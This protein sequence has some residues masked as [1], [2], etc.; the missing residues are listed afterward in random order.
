MLGE[1]YIRVK[2][3]NQAGDSQQQQQGNSTSEDM[4]GKSLGDAWA[5]ARRVEHRDAGDNQENGTFFAYE[6][7]EIVAYANA[8][9]AKVSEEFYPAAV[10][11]TDLSLQTKVAPAGGGSGSGGQKPQRMNVI[12]A[13]GVELQEPVAI[14]YFG[15]IISEKLAR[16]MAKSSMLP[17]R[18]IPDDAVQPDLF[19]EGGLANT[20][21]RTDFSVP[22]LIGP[23]M[24]PKEEAKEE[25]EQPPQPPTTESTPSG[26]GPTAS[27]PQASP[28]DR[29]RKA[30][31]KAPPVATH[32]LDYTKKTITITSRGR[33][34]KYGL[35]V[36]IDRPMDEKLV[37]VKCYRE[38]T[39]WD[40][41][42]DPWKVK[43]AKSIK[44]SLFALL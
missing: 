41:S 19:L 36:L 33:T 27:V 43:R 35:P 10:Q 30:A 22:W 7:R 38:P 42:D 34:F 40:L 14:P 21:E 25:E 28:R 3:P 11:K 4:K 29:K 18:K 13:K 1:K 9:M 44:K 5:Q 2:L 32:V 23:I 37:E 20:A 16:T 12:R 8:E 6:L 31:V 39:D 17:L 24:P 26:S 15:R